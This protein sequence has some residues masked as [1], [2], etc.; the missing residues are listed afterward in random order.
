MIVVIDYAVGNLAAVSN[1]F[2]RLGVALAEE[3]V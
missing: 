1:M 3:G 2:K